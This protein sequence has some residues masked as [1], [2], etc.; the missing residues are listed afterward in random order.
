MNKFIYKQ[1]N[2]IALALFVLVGMTDSTHLHASGREDTASLHASGYSGHASGSQ[3]PLPSQA[4]TTRMI[5]T[6][7]IQLISPN[8]EEIGQV[9]KLISLN[10]EE[11]GQVSIPAYTHKLISLNLEKGLV[12][13]PADTHKFIYI[14]S[15]IDK[16][17][18]RFLWNI[19]AEDDTLKKKIPND[20]LTDISR[21][22][23]PN[24]D[25][26]NTGHL[27]YSE[28]KESIM[29]STAYSIILPNGVRI[30]MKHEI[31]ELG[32]LMLTT[33]TIL[34]MQNIDWTNIETV[35][36]VR[37]NPLTNVLVGSTCKL[38]T[39]SSTYRNVDTNLWFYIHNSLQSQSDSPD[40]V[41]EGEINNIIRIRHEGEINN[42][43][44]IRHEGEYKARYKSAATWIKNNC[45]QLFGCTREQIHFIGRERS[46]DS[47]FAIRIDNS[48][49]SLGV[50]IDSSY[51]HEDKLLIRLSAVR[52]GNEMHELANNI[53][54][55]L[56]EAVHNPADDDEVVRV[57]DVDAIGGVPGSPAIDANAVVRVVDVDAGV[58][59]P[60]PAIL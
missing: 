37:L 43:I 23:N 32:E 50:S 2:K 38:V 49:I 45:E 40:R 51:L 3:D 42:I 18:R 8:G 60:N 11:I 27:K 20:L 1:S 56:N 24:E 35:Q 6:R 12:S 58:P 33:D 52:Y 53:H 16:E 7:M 4:N 47:D 54:A 14:P 17:V 41:L 13:I 26:C 28:I 10:G 55:I 29:H 59:V 34:S 15:M 5:T 57:V 48:S 46:D 22:Y 30:T 31:N 21:L 44:R 39:Y 25:K 36:L 19:F 9:I